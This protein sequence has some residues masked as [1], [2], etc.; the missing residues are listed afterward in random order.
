M[1]RGD[2]GEAKTYFDGLKQKL[3]DL[4]RDVSQN[5]IFDNIPNSAK[6]AINSA[7]AAF[8]NVDFNAPVE[9]IENKMANVYSTLSAG[10]KTA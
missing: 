2:K 3:L 4:R 10:F 9:E 5:G 8:K 6:K 7:E 1:A